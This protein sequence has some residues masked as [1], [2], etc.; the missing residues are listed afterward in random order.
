M[1]IDFLMIFLLGYLAFSNSVRAKLKGLNGLLWGFI[2]V[3]AFFTAMFIGYFFVI[4][5]FCTDLMDMKVMSSDDK[6]ARIALTEQLQ[7]I[8][9]ANPLHVMTIEAFAFGGYLL[10][11]YILEKKPG[12]KQTE[13]HWMDRLGENR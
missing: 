3:V 12:K 8:I 10:V 9:S 1:V 6:E 2:T 7:A 5:N 4:F 11:R 13:V